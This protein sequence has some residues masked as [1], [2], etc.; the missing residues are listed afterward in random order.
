MKFALDNQNICSYTVSMNFSIALEP[1]EKIA[2]MGDVNGFEAAG[3][4]PHAE[5]TRPSCFTPSPARPTRRERN[6][7]A[8]RRSI[9][10]VMTPRGP[11]PVLRTMMTTACERNCFYCA[12]RA[13]RSSTERLTFRPD[14]MAE[15]FARIRK[16]GLVDGL[17]LSS[18]II[19][20]GV[21]AQDQIID[22]AE[23]LR[24]KQ[25]YDGFIHL[26]IMPGAEYEQ[27]RRAMQLADR[28]SVNLEGATEGRLA[29]LAPKK[30]F[31][32]ELM[33]RLLW[34]ERIRRQERVRASSVTQFVVGA[35]GD[36]DLEL[37]SLSEKLYRQAGLRRVYYSS[38]SPVPDTPFENLSPVS[39]KREHRLYQASFLLRDY[40]WETEDIGFGS[41]QNL[42]LDVDP[43]Q[44]WAD[45]HL[46]GAPV[47]LNR[48][49]RQTLLRVPGIGPK[50]ADR[51]LRA[52]GQGRLTD[53]KELRALGVPS[54]QKA[55]P[56]VL[57][58]GRQPAHQ[59]VLFPVPG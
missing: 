41:D 36:T 50:S 8:L 15:G 6:A 45:L 12:F 40:S 10:Q 47:E 7:A 30:E 31:W 38:F 33:Q 39:R 5:P 23:I 2:R 29:R 20:G 11:K 24:K 56:Y 22:T 44:A 9:A 21:K 25:K 28:V 27:V 54:P 58:N 57:L 32:D 17:F 19:G 37:I 18:G 3:D 51:I 35:V 1:L 26:K 4:A 43:K 55:A 59:M 14:E 13:G 42:R 34:M 53:L 48:A 16:A 49:D 46:R 52:R